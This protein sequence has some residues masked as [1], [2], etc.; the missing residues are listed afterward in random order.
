MHPPACKE[1]NSTSS[2]SVFETMQMALFSLMAKGIRI[3]LYLDIWLLH[4]PTK[5]QAIHH[6][7]I[8]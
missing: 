5:E 8:L 3:L 1:E 2:M 7:C 4:A 6:T